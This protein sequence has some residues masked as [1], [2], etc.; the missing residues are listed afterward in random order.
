[1]KISIITVVYNNAAYIETCLKSV[2]SQIYPDK[3]YIVI[4]N[5]STDGTSEIINGY[6]GR[7][8]RVISEK[9]KGHIYAMNKGIRLSGGDVIGF[10]HSDDFYSHEKVI[11]MVAEQFEKTH[12]DSVYGDLVYVKKNNP[13]KIVRYWKGG[14]FGRDKIR[15]GWMPPH[16]TF[17]IKKTVYE[18]YGFLDTSFKISMD[19]EI[20]LRFLYKHNI[21]VSYLP[22]VLV[23]MREGG[24][25]NRSVRNI[26]RKTAEDYKACTM[27]GLGLST[28]AMKNV[29]KIPQFF[30]RK[31]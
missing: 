9:D 15:W 1:M 22:D 24:V 4:D 20:A 29:I 17:F 11:K 10:L 30:C 18:Q 23:K 31:T 13:N 8:S 26:L 19:Y 16:P 27:C 2:I 7:I 21:S 25:S 5:S 28:V 14:T 6:K 12:A 3:E